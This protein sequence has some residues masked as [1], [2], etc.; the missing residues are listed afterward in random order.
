MSDELLAASTA[1]E[2]D[3][4]TKLLQQGV[5][6]NSKQENGMTGLH[7]SAK[8][9]HDDIVKLFLDHEA[10]VNTPGAARYTP[11]IWAALGGHPEHRPASD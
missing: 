9:G 8:Q 6:V 1:G 4:V 7:E 2:T 3:T 11:L 5:N 10:D